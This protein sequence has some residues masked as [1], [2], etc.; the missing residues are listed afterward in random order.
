MKKLNLDTYPFDSIKIKT[1]E[2]AFNELLEELAKQD[3]IELEEDNILQ[4][5]KEK[6]NMGSLD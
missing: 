5:E 3:I 4:E 2:N 6:E 1:I